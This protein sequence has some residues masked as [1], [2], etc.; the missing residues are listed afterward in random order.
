MKAVRYK[1]SDGREIPAYLT[2]PKASD[3][4]ISVGSFFILCQNRSAGTIETLTFTNKRNSGKQK[5]GNI[6]ISPRLKYVKNANN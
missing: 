4:F 3:L 6:S 5:A 2:I 1:S